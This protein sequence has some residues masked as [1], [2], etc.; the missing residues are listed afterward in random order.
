VSESGTTICLHCGAKFKGLTDY[1]VH[2]DQ[3]R[4]RLRE[5][6]YAG[7]IVEGRNGCLR[8]QRGRR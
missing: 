5:P 2:W 3:G 7:E 4:C 1:T 6:V 8:I